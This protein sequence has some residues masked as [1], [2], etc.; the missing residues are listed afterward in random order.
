MERGDLLVGEWVIR[1]SGPSEEGLI[2][3]KWR[4]NL[5]SKVG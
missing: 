2:V 1:D 3:E 5:A 4:V